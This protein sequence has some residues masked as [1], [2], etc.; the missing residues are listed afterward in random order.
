MGACQL[1]HTTATVI[2]LCRCEGHDW[3]Q[4]SRLQCRSMCGRIHLSNLKDLSHYAGANASTH[5]H[6]HA[7]AHIA[8]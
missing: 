6:A 4:V 5:S 2:A 7:H 1:K 3:G 8:Q